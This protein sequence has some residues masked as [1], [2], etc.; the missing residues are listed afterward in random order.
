MG[1]QVFIKNRLSESGKLKASKHSRVTV[2]GAADPVMTTLAKSVIP[3]ALS[4][5]HGCIIL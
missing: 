3:V 5:G 1:C 2:P 4:V